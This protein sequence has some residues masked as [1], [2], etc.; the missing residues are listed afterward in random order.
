MIADFVK[1]TQEQENSK[2]QE[3]RQF[4]SIG[5]TH[6]N[7]TDGLRYVKASVTPSLYVF[8]IRSYIGSVNG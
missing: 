1:I 6:L 7:P 2:G 4:H 5:F 3:S 8:S